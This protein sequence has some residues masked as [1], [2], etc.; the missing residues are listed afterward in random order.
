MRLVSHARV[1]VVPGIVLL[2]LGAAAAFLLDAPR[3]GGA[4]SAVL[5]GTIALTVW[6]MRARLS[7]LAHMARLSAERQ[8]RHSELLV[9]RKK[10]A[11]VAGVDLGRPGPRAPEPSES[12]ARLERLERRLLAA[13][14]D[15]Q[16]RAEDRYAR[17]LDALAGRPR[18][19]SVHEPTQ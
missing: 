10:E 18:D 2:V 5:L 9:S 13:A 8:R 14:Y 15:E 16:I 19:G 1:V 7:D 12:E 11:S 3:I 6:Q 17:L 4:V